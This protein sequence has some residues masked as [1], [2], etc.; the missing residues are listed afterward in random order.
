[1]TPPGSILLDVKGSCFLAIVDEIVANVVESGGLAAECA[2]QVR[3]LLLKKHKHT[4]DTTLW[5]KIKNSATGEGD[6][7]GG[8]GLQLSKWIA[9]R[10]P[11]QQNQLHF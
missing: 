3:M 5:E 8:G 1:M 11:K 2:D 4:N 6:S 7:N 10:Y 9:N